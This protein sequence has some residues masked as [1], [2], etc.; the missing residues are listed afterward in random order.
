MN[1]PR[2]DFCLDTHLRILAW[3]HISTGTAYHPAP[4]PTIEP[5]TLP[6]PGFTP[7]FAIPS[8]QDPGPEAGSCVRPWDFASLN[9][10]LQGLQGPVSRVIHKQ[11]KGPLVRQSPEPNIAPPSR[12]HRCAGLLRGAGHTTRTQFHTRFR[13]YYPY[14][15]P[16]P[17]HI[18]RV[19][20]IRMLRF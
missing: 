2:P 6:V 1:Q 4:L 18:L 19:E 9:S 16:Y 11:K 15:P 14:P 12:C 8:Q 3:A 20:G 17:V 10:R 13:T 7:F 5:F